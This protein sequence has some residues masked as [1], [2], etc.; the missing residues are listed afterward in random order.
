ME[1]YLVKMS[2]FSAVIRHTIAINLFA[3]RVIGAKTIS[4]IIRNTEKNINTKE[5]YQYHFY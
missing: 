4:N 3:D 5:I 1:T 2:S